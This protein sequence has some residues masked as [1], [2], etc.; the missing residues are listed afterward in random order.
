[1]ARSIPKDVPKLTGLGRK[2]RHAPGG[3]QASRV[4]SEG[5]SSEYDAKWNPL[6]DNH[7]VFE[8]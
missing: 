8:Q 3:M 4:P 6:E 5:G 2:T 1:M 7:E